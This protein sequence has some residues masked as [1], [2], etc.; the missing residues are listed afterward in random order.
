MKIFLRSLPHGSH[1]S[2][3]SFGSDYDLMK[4]DGVD[5]IK[6]DQKN[7]KN[8]IEQ[9]DKFDANY[10]GTEILNPMKHAL[11]MEWNG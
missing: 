7:I 2:I 3:I 11:E 10:G 4:I 6:Y 8:A 5:K 1:F 9:L